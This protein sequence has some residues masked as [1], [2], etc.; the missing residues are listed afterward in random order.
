MF[1]CEILGEW[2]ACWNDCEEC[3][4]WMEEYGIL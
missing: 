1:Y 4:I 2:V 3:E